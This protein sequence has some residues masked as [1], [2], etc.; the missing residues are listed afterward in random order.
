MAL[1]GAS[2]RT[3]VRYRRNATGTH[4]LLL[5]LVPPNS[6]VLDVGCAGGYLGETLTEKGCRVCGLDR[7]ADAIRSA[8]IH[9]EEA[10]LIDLE[11]AA[12]LPWPERSFDVL[13]AADVLE[14]LRDPSTALA[15][16]VRY[17]R[18][19]GL[20]VV[21][22]PNVAHASVRIPLLFGHF[23]YRERGILDATHCRLFTFNSAR[24][25]VESSGLWIEDTL[26]GSDRLGVLLNRWRPARRLLRGLLAY[27][28]V[29]RARP[30]GER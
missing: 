3:P 20:A 22:L 11:S 14:H 17:L 8:R 6:A 30:L 15:M 29:L 7:N 28:I 4:R 1:A 25:L 21:S 26:V 27:N 9:Y 12:S 10:R 5:N 23:T 19:D 18:H 2:E 13:L 16:L 24:E